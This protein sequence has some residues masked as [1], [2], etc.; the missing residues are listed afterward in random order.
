MFQSSAL[1]RSDKKGREASFN[2]I[3]EILSKVPY[4]RLDNRPDREAVSLTETL[5]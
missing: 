4:Y 3:T 1:L 2:L 5:I